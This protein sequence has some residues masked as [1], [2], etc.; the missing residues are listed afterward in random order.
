[1]KSGLE[2]RNNPSRAAVAVGPTASLNE[3]RPGR[4][5]QSPMYMWLCEQNGIV[6]MKSGLEDRNNT[7]TGSLG[8]P[9]EVCLNEVRPGRPEQSNIRGIARTVTACL[10]EVRPGRPEQL[11]TTA[12]KRDSLEWSQ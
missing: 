4:P 7:S 9:L 11:I 1:M 5:E 3:V 2:D 12:R 6:S 10:N 8:S